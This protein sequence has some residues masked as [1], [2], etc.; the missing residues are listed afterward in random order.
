MFETLLA[1]TTTAKKP[2]R[3][4]FENEREMNIKILN[5]VD[6]DHEEESLKHVLALLYAN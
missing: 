1:S 3:W 5:L 4:L 6:N 2:K